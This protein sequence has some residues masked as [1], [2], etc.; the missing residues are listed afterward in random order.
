MKLIDFHCDTFWAMEKQAPLCV[1]IE[2][3]KNADSLAQFFACFVYMDDFKGNYTQG[4]EH[5]LE[6]LHNAKVFLEIHQK[7]IELTEDYE[8]VLKNHTKR[9]I[10]EI[11]SS[12]ACTVSSTDCPSVSRT[13]SAYRLYK[14]VRC[15]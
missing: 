9:K 13:I 2:K 8:G 10:S 7:E 12:T 3:L 4:Y 1:D 15:S 14:G 6:M 5:A 11:R